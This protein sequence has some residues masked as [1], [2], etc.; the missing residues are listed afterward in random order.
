MSN[1]RLKIILRRKLSPCPNDQSKGLKHAEK[2]TFG[3][4]KEYECK[5]LEKSSTQHRQLEEGG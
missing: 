1:V 2:M 4:Y 3:R 5:Q